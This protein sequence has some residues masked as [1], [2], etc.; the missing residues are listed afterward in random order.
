MRRFQF[1]IKCLLRMIQIQKDNSVLCPSTLYE[2]LFTIYLTAVRSDLEKDLRRLLNLSDFTKSALKEYILTR[3]EKVN[4]FYTVRKKLIH[5]I[6]K[7][8]S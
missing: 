2:G 3:K 5:T 1:A 6:M 7:K 8:G 4:N